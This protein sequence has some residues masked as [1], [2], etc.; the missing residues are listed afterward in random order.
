LK[1]IIDMPKNY[2]V[3]KIIFKG[4]EIYSEID[5]PRDVS[6]VV[7]GIGYGAGIL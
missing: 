1:G 4:R 5:V 3:F 6:S 2:K 7:C